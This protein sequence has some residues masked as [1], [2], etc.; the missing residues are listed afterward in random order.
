MLFSFIFSTN[1]YCHF[2]QLAVLKIGGKASKPPATCICIAK[3]LNGYMLNLVRGYFYFLSRPMSP[4]DELKPI[5]W[6]HGCKPE[7]I[8][9]TLPNCPV[10]KQYTI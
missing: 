3:I 9:P 1:C 10:L 7:L 5:T 8:V 4:L 2:K 6:V